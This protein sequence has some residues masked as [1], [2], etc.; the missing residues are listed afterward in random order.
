[1][2]TSPRVLVDYE[3]I[4][5][6]CPFRDWLESLDYTTI[7]RIEARLKRIAFGN[8]GDVKPVG[9]G[10]SEIRMKFRRG[11][12]VYFSRYGDTIVVLFCGGDKG[13]Q[14]KDIEK[15]KTYWSEFKRRNNATE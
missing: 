5:G 4:N 7:A 12:R 2:K 11:Y 3:T 14:T 1:M 9:G 10:V 15:A 8:F 13:S 6:D